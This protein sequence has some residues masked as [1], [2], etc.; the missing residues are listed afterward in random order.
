MNLVKCLVWDLDAT[1]WHGVL[2][3]ADEP[4]L[5]PEAHAALVELDRRGVLHAVASKNDHDAAWAKLEELGVAKYFVAARIGWGPKSDS[6]REI[7]EELGFALDTIAF[8]DDQ[9]VEQAEV[10]FHLPA[11][12]CYLADRVSDLVTLPEFDVPRTATAARRRELYQARSRRAA[13]R[14]EFTSTDEDFLRSLDAVMTIGQ[15]TAAD[16]D[17]LAELTRRTS[18]M[19]ATGVHYSHEVLEALLSDADHEVLVVRLRDRFGDHGEVG[20]VLLDRGAAVWHLKLLAT[21]CRVVSYGVGSTVLRWLIDRAVGAKVHLVA[22]FRRTERNRMMAVT[23]RFAG[24]EDR[25]CECVADLVPSTADVR[26]LHLE[27][28]PQPVSRTVRLLTA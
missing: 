13:A 6:V 26:R 10:A 14:R 9:A 2:A 16:L 23:Y 25:S 8:V 15:A 17:R 7:A 20:I 12:R 24:F 27:P 11:V 1:L 22:D 4:R 28:T 21:S 3:E 19:N 18:Q 5:R